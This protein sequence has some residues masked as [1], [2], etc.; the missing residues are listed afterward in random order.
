MLGRVVSV[1]DLAGCSARDLAE[2]SRAVEQQRLVVAVEQSRLI[3]HVEST[4]SYG[5]DGHRTVSAWLRATHRWSVGEAARHVQRAHLL[6]DHPSVVEAMLDGR[7]GLP[8][9]DVLARAA[10]NPRCSDLF[11]EFVGIFLHAATRI[12]FREFFELVADWVRRADEDGAFKDADAAHRNRSMSWSDTPDGGLTL[13]GRFAA[14]QASEI[15]AVLEAYL[16]TE[17]LADMDQADLA[18]AD[19]REQPVQR[20]APQRRADALHAICLDAAASPPGAQRP[21]P[22]VN[23]TADPATLL[24]FFTDLGLDPTG[25]V[26]TG[27]DH[28]GPATSRPAPVPPIVPFSRDAPDDEL[29]ASDDELDPD[30]GEDMSAMSAEA[31]AAA[32]ARAL[33]IGHPRTMDGHLVP[34]ADIISALFVGQVRKVLTDERGVITHAG[35]ARRLFTGVLRRLV[36]MAATHCIWPGCDRPASQCQADH[37]DPYAGAGRTDIDNGA[38]LCG[39]HNR[40]KTHGYRTWRDPDGRWHTHRPDGTEI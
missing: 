18:E 26:V 40:Y 32:L 15:R 29:D 6:R 16:H 30:D 38:P 19:Q 8:Q 25:S 31:V 36:L 1:E 13:R 10:A 33:A 27:A 22:V 21:E 4:G 5:V 2:H 12:H 28:T 9:V 24:Q 39:F 3:A 7:I 14:A 11:G 23:L 20:T 17:F 34:V 35:R 37:V